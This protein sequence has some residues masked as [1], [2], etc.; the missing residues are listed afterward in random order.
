[1]TAHCSGRELSIKKRAKRA[2]AFGEVILSGFDGGAHAKF[3]QN[4]TG[5]KQLRICLGTSVLQPQSTIYGKA[6]RSQWTSEPGEQGG[7]CGS[8]SWALKTVPKGTYLH[9][10][11]P[12]WASPPWASPPRALTSMGL[13]SWA[14][15]S[16]G[17]HLHGYSPPRQYSTTNT[18]FLP[19]LCL[20]FSLPFN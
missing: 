16:M 15:T 6:N 7:S 14:L 1:M 2:T 5:L 13:T 18:N 20:I 4:P 17:T 9:G 11:S 8:L 19:C 12:P 3:Q 10:H